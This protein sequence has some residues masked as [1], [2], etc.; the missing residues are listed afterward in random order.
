MNTEPKIKTKNLFTDLTHK[1]LV[2]RRT[3]I[4][5]TIGPSTSS[6]EVLTTLIK[7]GLNVA[8]INFSH[9]DPEDHLKVIQRIRDI[10]TKLDKSI[11]ILGD[12]CGPKVRVGKFEG[13]GLQLVDN[14]NVLITTEDILGHDN[15]IPSQYKGII[16]E[17]KC[18]DRVLLDDG[19][20]ELRILGKKDNKL[21]AK[22]IRGGL[23]KNNKGMNLPDTKMNIS[24]LTDKDK[25]DVKYCVRGEVDYIALSFVRYA[26][27]VEELKDFMKNMG[28]YI[29]IIA[30]IEKP[31]A[32]KN[33]ENI[34]DVADGIMIARGDLGVEMPPEKV[35]HIQN[36]LIQLSNSHNKPVI[37]ATQMLESMIEHSRPTRAEVTDVAGACL[38]GADA[39]M[40]SGETTVG[41]YPVETF[42][43]M[44]SILRE[45]ETYQFFSNGGSFKIY[46]NN[47][48][49]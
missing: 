26:T 23:L 36:K 24:A 19:N 22:V 16:N 43:V 21:E 30:K 42:E 3:K 4:I 31:E 49:R 20:L 12:L 7:K 9:G 15:I 18:G 2:F 8:R 29:P 44:D 35:P 17:A 39:V 33:I 10:S 1:H 48:N 46:D 28:A 37:V 14:T 6:E 45:T 13:N 32:L 40:L 41:K 38:A 47:L 25:N 27:D 11:A 5:A 34:I